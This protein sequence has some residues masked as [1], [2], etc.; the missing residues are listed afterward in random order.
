MGTTKK[1]RNKLDEMLL[2]EFAKLSK[3]IKYSESISNLNFLKTF[4]VD[5]WY[6][7]L[8][9][10]VSQWTFNY[11]RYFCQVIILFTILYCLKYFYKFTQYNLF[12]LELV[13]SLAN[14]YF[15][16]LFL[17]KFSVLWVSSD[18]VDW[19]QSVFRQLLPF[20]NLI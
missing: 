11:R 10:Y 4:P 8:Q 15:L 3:T 2:F 17:R 7:L 9:L 20:N 5:K 12:K 6:E 14:L 13:F 16:N 19:A 1:V 18:R